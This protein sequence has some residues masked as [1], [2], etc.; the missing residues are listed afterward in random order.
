MTKVWESRRNG[1]DFVSHN[2][3]PCRFVA[4]RIRLGPGPTWVIQANHGLPLRPRTDLRS[5]TSRTATCEPQASRI[6]SATRGARAKAEEAFGR[7]KGAFRF[8]RPSELGGKPGW[9]EIRN[10]VNLFVCF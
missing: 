10:T 2:Y 7:E 3:A 6:A 9:S 8:R 1:R 5:W 4:G